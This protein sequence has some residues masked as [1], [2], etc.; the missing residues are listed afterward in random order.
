MKN[1]DTTLHSSGRMRPQTTSSTSDGVAGVR[2]DQDNRILLYQELE[3][4]FQI[5]FASDSPSPPFLGRGSGGTAATGGSSS[6]R[7]LSEE[8]TTI[9]E[10]YCYDYAYC[11][12]QA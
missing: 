3:E 10:R 8:T 11:K 2:S 6:R 7:L 4:D 1:Q 9:P 12:N 5:V